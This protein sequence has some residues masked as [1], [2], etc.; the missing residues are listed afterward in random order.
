MREFEPYVIAF[1]SHNSL[2]QTRP[3]PPFER[4][5]GLAGVCIIILLPTVWLWAGSRLRR[6]AVTCVYSLASQTPYIALVS[7]VSYI[8]EKQFGS[9]QHYESRPYYRLEN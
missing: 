8:S 1:Q 2:M 3:S 7:T 9:C 5:Y 4:G 6:L